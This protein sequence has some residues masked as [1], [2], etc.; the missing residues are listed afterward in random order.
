MGKTT[1]SHQLFRKGE[2]ELLVYF[3]MV[4]HRIQ[5]KESRSLKFTVFLKYKEEQ[6][7]SCYGLTVPPPNLCVE[8]LTPRTPQY[9]CVWR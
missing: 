2:G 4:L 9:E 6:E 1:E 3:C 8:V 5:S 7:K